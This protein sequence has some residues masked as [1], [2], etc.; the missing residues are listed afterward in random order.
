M[1]AHRDTQVSKIEEFIKISNKFKVG[2]M[3]SCVSEQKEITSD[4][5]VLIIVSGT[6]IEFEDI[7]QI[8]LALRKRQKRERDSEIF[9]QEIENLL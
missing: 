9:R 7:A 2:N 6:N 8:P 3:V 1:L 4:V 5:W